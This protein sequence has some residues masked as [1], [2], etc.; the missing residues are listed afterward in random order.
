MEGTRRELPFHPSCAAVSQAVIRVA[1]ER[2]TALDSLGDARFIGI[3]AVAWSFGIAPW[4]LFVV[5]R[6]IPVG[7]PF[8]NVARQVVQAVAVWRKRLDGGGGFVAIRNVV[9]FG[10]F[11]LPDVSH[12]ASTDFQR[13]TPRI[14]LLLATATRRELK[15]SFGRQPLAGPLAVSHGI[16]PRDMDHRVI[17]FAIQVGVR[18]RRMTPVG[19]FL[20]LPNLMR[21]VGVIFAERRAIEVGIEAERAGNQVLLFD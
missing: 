11:S 9:D 17:L 6:L 3:K 18:S 4:A 14:R 20:D 10:K 8:P 2:P 16:R 15:L 12:P 21:P 13:L 1:H 7:T 19:S 5:G